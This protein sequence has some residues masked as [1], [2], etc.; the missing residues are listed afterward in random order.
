MRRIHLLFMFAFLTVLIGCKGNSSEK[1]DYTAEKQ[2]DANN[3]NYEKVNNDP[4]GLRLYTLENGLKVYLS[5]NTDEPKIQTYIAVRAGSNYDPKETTGLAHYLEHMLFK[6][7]E[8]FGTA[9]WE[10]EQ[11]Y[12]SQIS[13]LYEEHKAEADADKKKDV[14]RKIDSVSLEASKFAIANE[15]DKMTASIGAQGTNAHTWF[16]ETVYHNKIPSNELNKWL[17]LEGERFSQ[18]VLRL[19]HTEL[20]AVFE[21]FN[22]GQDNDYRKIYASMLKGLFPNHPYGQQST[23]GTAEHLK[24]PSMIA[25]HNYFNKYYVPNNMALILVGDI[26]FEETIKKVNETFGKLEN[27]EVSHPTL[28]KEEPITSPIVNEVFGPT[29]ESVSVAFRSQGV[30][31]E[32]EKLMTLA[33]MILANG[34]AG[35][36]DLNLNQ[37]QAVQN[38]SCSPT[39]LNDYG[40]HSFTGSPKEG[41]TLDEVKDLLLEQIE[42]LKK[43]EFED[44]MIEAVVN[45]LKL[46]RT[47]QYE[48]NSALASMYYDAFIHHEDW[49]NK[50]KFLDDLKKISKQQLVD[51]ANNFYTNNYVLTYKRK[52]EDKSIVKVENPGITPIEVNRDMQSDYVKQFNT[53]VSQDLKPRFVDYKNEIKQT[54]LSS[55]IN[56]DY[57]ENKNNDLF[58]LNIIFDMGS[59]SNK[60]LSLAVGYLD[61][62]GTEKLSPENLKKEFYKLG[63]SYGVQ[64]QG[65]KSYVYISGLNEN[66]DKGLDLLEDLWDHSEANE[67]TYK[68]YV[69]KILKDR[70]DSKTQKG[71]I[72][73]NGL[74]S[75]AKYGENSR[76][77]NI[78]TAEELYAIS[79]TDL[80][81]LLKDLKSYKQRVF[82]YGKDVDAAVGA[83][84]TAH[85]VPEN[86]KDYPTPIEYVEKETGEQVY[87]TDYDMVQSELIFLSKGKQF[88]PKEL[89]LSRVFNSYFGSGLSSIVFQE[90]RESKSLAYSAFAAYSDASKKGDSNYIYGYV[91]T[92]ANKLPQAVDAMLEL[93]NNMPEADKQ[94]NSAKEAV[95]KQ[96]AAERITKSNIFWSYERLKNRGLDYDNRE[97]IYNEVQNITL[98]DLS[99]FFNTNIKGKKYTTLVIGN[100][101]DLNVEALKKLGKVTELDVDYLFNYKITPVKQ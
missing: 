71:N 98:K 15:Y 60:Q 32:E 74:F 63:V 12:L 30:G 93:M 96:I 84:N 37:K 73:W 24:N 61:F 100:K 34:E 92:Q 76:L 50:V 46:S 29:S 9:D 40:Y 66:L 25:I 97:E 99:N 13:D 16:E 36:I 81:N 90:I 54:T 69:E 49:A 10:T 42:K 67:E 5:K 6:G 83:M 82:Y 75:Y 53:E 8:E 35:L 28:P 27:K 52:G 77:R 64:A 41:Q 45:D 70:V 23:I 33:D 22:R 11:E 48:N 80:V 21:E 1:G 20:E 62:L 87:F 39:F 68:K 3:F 17:S 65:D 4:T 38:A 56:V 101:K 86:L 88:D 44:W 14:Y 57:V 72:L 43:G 19:F 7:T 59:D 95:L 47:R 58:D 79:P 78:F 31:T 55:G 89:A 91:G 18:L 94:F 26:N 85:S 2:T 51:F